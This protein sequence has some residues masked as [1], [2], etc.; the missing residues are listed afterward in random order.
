MLNRLVNYFLPQLSHP[1][2]NVR[3]RVAS[4][5]ASLL[6]MDI[7]LKNYVNTRNATRKLVFD[8][9]AD[10]LRPLVAYVAS[11]PASVNGAEQAKVDG[12]DAGGEPESRP[13]KSG[14]SVQ[15]GVV[16]EA[17][18][19]TSTS[20]DEVEVAKRLMDSVSRVIFGCMNRAFFASPTEFHEL[21]PLV[22]FL[23]PAFQI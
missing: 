20:S 23:R 12:D 16:V 8:R 17:S 6:I 2:Q 9:L 22:S 11:A 3:D 1:F 13:V 19:A 18:T 21:I 15:N 10:G 4:V 14:A 7:P 5:V